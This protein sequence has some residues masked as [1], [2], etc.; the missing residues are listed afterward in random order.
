MPIILAQN[1]PAYSELERDNVFVM[2]TARAQKQDIRPL[3]IVL[4]NLMP[5]KIQTETQL[6]RVLANSPL[7]VEL[8]LV[9]M[10]SH[11]SK[12]VSG[13]HL[14]AFYKTFNE[15]KHQRFDGMIITGAPVEHFQFEQV[16]YWAELSEIMEFSKTN[17]YSTFHICWGAQAA[18]YYHYNIQK[19]LLPQKCSGVFAH[20]VTRPKNP[21]VRGF[22]EVFFAP[23]SRH[24]TVDEQAVLQCEELRV[25]AKSDEAGLHLLSTENGRQI[26]AFGHMEYDKYTL[27]DEYERDIL[28]NP[29]AALPKNYFYGDDANNDVNYCWRAHAQLLFIN[30]LNYYVYQATPFELDNL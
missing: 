17:V 5:T 18:L 26:Y 24:A 6:A 28:K 13:T 16:N 20:R 1:L 3:K 12:N 27:R 19:T 14:Q 9:H 21:L 23:H 2:R 8:S 25:L 10:G 30:W 29:N 4:V 22:D 11:E 15:I 7:Q